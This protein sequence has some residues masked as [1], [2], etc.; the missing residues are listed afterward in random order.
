MSEWEIEGQGGSTEGLDD[1]EPSDDDD[2]EPSIGDLGTEGGEPGGAD[3][4]EYGAGM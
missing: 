1:D 3:D 4:E 2:D